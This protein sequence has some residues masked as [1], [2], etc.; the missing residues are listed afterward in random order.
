MAIVTISTQSPFLRFAHRGETFP[1]DGKEEHS[2]PGAPE[3]EERERTESDSPATKPT[4]G[5]NEECKEPTTPPLTTEPNVSENEERKN[6]ARKAALRSTVC[7]KFKSLRNKS[8]RANFTSHFGF[9]QIVQSLVT[10][11]A[12]LEPPSTDDE[13]STSPAIQKSSLPKWQHRKASRST[14][15]PPSPHFEK[16]SSNSTPWTFWSLLML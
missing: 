11:V 9:T 1:H 4:V 12:T 15:K 8:G 7:N 3:T 2:E 5:E 10:A 13:L 14:D 16:N 6:A